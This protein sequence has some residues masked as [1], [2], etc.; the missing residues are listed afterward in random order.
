MQV[1]RFVL[2][3]SKQIF[4]VPAAVTSLSADVGWIRICPRLFSLSLNYPNSPHFYWATFIAD[5]LI[6]QKLQI[7]RPV[8]ATSE[9]VAVGMQF[10]RLLRSS[11]I[12]SPIP[13]LL[14]P[15]NRSQGPRKLKH[16]SRASK[17]RRL[18][19]KSFSGLFRRVRAAFA[20][21]G[22]ARTI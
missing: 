12:A 13:H 21:E 4:A 18:L 19:D 10:L 7:I 11:P 17:L 5:R 16:T 15:S 6:I 20:S 8:S 14:H 9:A 22:H 2:V 1:R 3:A